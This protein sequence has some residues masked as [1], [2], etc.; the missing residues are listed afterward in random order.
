MRST[1]TMFRLINRNTIS[2]NVCWGDKTDDT[3]YVAINPFTGSED[4]DFSR[5]QV[6]TLIDALH[7][8][9]FPVKVIMIGQSAKI[10]SPALENVVVVE[11]STINSA[12]EIVRCSDLRSRL[13]C[14][15][16]RALD[17]PLIAVYNKRKLKDTGLPCYKFG[18]PTTQRPSRS[19]ATR[20]LSLR[21]LLTI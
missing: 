2:C 13:H 5:E 10:A 20:I 6:V 9:P 17:K 16:F 3:R 8:L 18:P 4:K 15:Y 14:A 7:S 19:S 1:T 11:N 12:V 21:C